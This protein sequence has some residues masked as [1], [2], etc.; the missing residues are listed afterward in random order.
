MA[1]TVGCLFGSSSGLSNGADEFTATFT[2]TDKTGTSRT[3]QMCWRRASGSPA[4]PV[5][6]LEFGSPNC[7]TPTTPANPLLVYLD[8]DFMIDRQGGGSNYYFRGA[9]I[10]LV[11]GVVKIE[12]NWYPC[13]TT[14]AGTACNAQTFPEDHLFAVLTPND[15][16]I[17][18]STNNIDAIF[19][20]FYTAS[21]FYSERDDTDILGG[22]IARRLCVANGDCPASS[23]TKVPRFFEVPQ[24]PR[25]LPAELFLGS[26]KRW[27]VS[28]VLGFWRE[29]RPGAT[30]TV[31]ATVTGLCGYS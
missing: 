12:E 16:Q 24:D 29:C 10:F 23:G 20:F 30:P 27:A 22:I 15:M 26:S 13:R 31:P 4:P 8:S 14:G 17:A 6:T 11:T 3:G 25:T 1:G 7:D 19:G 2:F 28:S 9:A 18:K 21:D 5:R